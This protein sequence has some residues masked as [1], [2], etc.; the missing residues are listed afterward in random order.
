MAR[1]RRAGKNQRKAALGILD[2]GN[3]TINPGIRPGDERLLVQTNA[4]VIEDPHALVFVRR[5]D[6]DRIHRRFR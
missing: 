2:V 6:V 4:R 1:E 5:D 3:D